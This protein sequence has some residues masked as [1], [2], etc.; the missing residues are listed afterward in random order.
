MEKKIYI[1]SD[2]SFIRAPFSR[3][4]RHPDRILRE[5]FFVL[6]FDWITVEILVPE[7]DV[8]IWEPMYRNNRIPARSSGNNLIGDLFSHPEIIRLSTSSSNRRLNLFEKVGYFPKHTTTTG[9]TLTFNLHTSS[10][11]N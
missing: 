8:K 5:R 10:E 1:Y 11:T 6:Y 2:V 7:L 4:I 3:K 9:K